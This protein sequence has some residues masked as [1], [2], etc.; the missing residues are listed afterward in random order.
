MCGR[1][2]LSTP[3]DLIAEFLELAEAP[4]VGP[5]Y[6]IAPTQEAP[7]VRF[8]PDRGGRHAALA[9]WGLVPFWAKDPAIGNRMINARAETAAEKPAFRSSFRKR[10]CIVVADGFYEWKKVAGPKQPYLLRPRGGPLFA[11]AGLWDRWGRGE[12]ALETYAILT[13]EPNGVVAPIHR[14]M[15]AV[16]SPEHWAAWLD[17]ELEDPARVGAMLGPCPEEWIEALPVSTYVNNPAN[18]SPRCVEP[19]AAPPEAR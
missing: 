18:D 17:P 5:R 13:T 16:L 11:L 14:R 4:E 1:Y 3:P 19:L 6:N 15:P 7:I 2:T 12:E 9:R 8:S 10:R